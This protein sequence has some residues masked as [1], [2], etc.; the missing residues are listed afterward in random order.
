M[1]RKEPFLGI[2]LLFNLSDDDVAAFAV[3]RH[4]FPGVDIAAHSSRRYPTKALAAHA[5]GYVGRINEHELNEL[6]P[7]D[8]NGTS[9]IGKLGIEK[10]YEN[11]L[12]GKAGFQHV[13]INAQGRPLRV[14]DEQPPVPGADL[15]LSLDTGLQ[16][17]AEQALGQSC[18]GH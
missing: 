16:R 15:V 18:G 1:Q 14:L 3:N 12:H 7:K 5:L 11:L 4:R 2:P 8:S 9:H 13:E 10:Y 6:D 17:V